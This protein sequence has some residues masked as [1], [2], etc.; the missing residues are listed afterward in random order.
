MSRY[1]EPDLVSTIALAGAKFGWANLFL[2][3]SLPSDR[4]E[5]IMTFPRISPKCVTAQP[6]ICG[7]V[8]FLA[9][10][11]LEAAGESKGLA[12][13]ERAAVLLAAN[14]ACDFS[15]SFLEPSSSCLNLSFSPCTCLI[16]FSCS[17]DLVVT[18]EICL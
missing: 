6:D 7:M 4:L 2:T 18:S 10:L 12:G 9:V 13:A 5:C 14:D 8:L 1:N 16:C 15:I 17:L 3:M 11:A